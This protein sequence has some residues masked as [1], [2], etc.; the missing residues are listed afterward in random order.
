MKLII[1][2]SNSSGNS[3]ILDNGKEALLIECGV[4]FKAIKQALGFS[5]ARV[6]AC[7]VTHEHKDHCKAV[8]DI[9]KGGIKVLT[10]EQTHK[11][12]GTDGHYNSRFTEK[13]PQ[14]SYFKTAFEGF[15]IQPFTVKH[16]AAEPVGYLINHEECGN[17]LFLTDS[18]YCEY[19]FKGLNN[20]I[21]EA[22]YCQKILDDKVAAGVSPE[23]LRN[24]VLESHMSLTTCKEMLQANDLSQVNNIVLIH[25]SDS[26]SDAVRFGKEVREV[27]GKTVH[28]AAAGMVI[29]NFNKSPF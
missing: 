13:K 26:N 3:Y 18:Y 22:N 2:G 5:L 20:V 14:G 9:L 1:I 8:N 7:I 4:S 11:A 12:M 16:D 10:S 28:V 17:V 23:F 29:E 24:R 19:T 25:L 27:T 6:A 15:T 21:I